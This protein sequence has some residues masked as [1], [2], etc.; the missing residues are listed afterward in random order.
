MSTWICLFPPRENE[1]SAFIKTKHHDEKNIQRYFVKRV[2]R[3]LMS[4]SRFA[5]FSSVAV[6]TSDSSFMSLN[7]VDVVSYGEH[8]SLL[9][10]VFPTLSFEDGIESTL[11]YRLSALNWCFHE[12][13]QDGPDEHSAEKRL[14]DRVSRDVSSGNA[15]IDTVHRDSRA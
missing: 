5:S 14:V 13:L 2:H 10:V 3:S 15:R 4:Q 7:R 12:R 11:Q 6:G 1:V 9:P 8:R